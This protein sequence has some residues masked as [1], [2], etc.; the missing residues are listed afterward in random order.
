MSLSMAGCLLAGIHLHSRSFNTCV[1]GG[2][3]SRPIAKLAYRLCAPVR[4][5]SR[6]ILRILAVEFCSFPFRIATILRE[7]SLRLGVPVPLHPEDYSLGNFEKANNYLR[8]C[9]EGIRRLQ[10]QRRIT[11]SLDF[12]IHVQAFQQGATWA[13]HNL[14][15]GKHIDVP[16]E[17]SRD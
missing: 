13:L 16:R 4:W 10:N 7:T 5:Y 1:R 8:A 9:T 15:N 11:S 3:A 17:S 2:S 6:S 12:Q 14:C